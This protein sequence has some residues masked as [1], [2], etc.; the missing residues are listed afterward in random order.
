MACLQDFIAQVSRDDEREL[1]SNCGVKGLDENRV[2]EAEGRR[3]VL[4]SP[5]HSDIVPFKVTR[6]VAQLGVSTLLSS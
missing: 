2:F 1:R 6:H 5:W 3:V 4:E